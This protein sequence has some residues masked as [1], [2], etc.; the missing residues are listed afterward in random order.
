LSQKNLKQTLRNFKFKS[1][2]VQRQSL[3]FGEWAYAI[4]S[5]LPD[6][7]KL[8]KAREATNPLLV[9]TIEGIQSD[10]DETYP[11]LGKKLIDGSCKASDVAVHPIYYVSTNREE[12]TEL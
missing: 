11:G 4:D 6:I 9:K 2:R 5:L 8:N 12:D 7:R 1:E 3:C 10:M